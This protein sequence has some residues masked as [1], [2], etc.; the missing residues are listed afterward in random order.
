MSLWATD[1]LNSHIPLQTIAYEA[2]T[3]GRERPV[4]ALC[5]RGDV[6]QFRNE[7]ALGSLALDGFATPIIAL[8]GGDIGMPRQSLHSGDIGAGIEQVADVGPTQVVWAE[9]LDASF[10][11]PP[12]QDPAH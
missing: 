7:E 1:N 2:D 3:T 10:L 4:N 11:G 5:S 9:A 12:P 6:G 8:G